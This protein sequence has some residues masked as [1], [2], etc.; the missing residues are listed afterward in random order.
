MSCH[1][2]RINKARNSH[3]VHQLLRHPITLITPEAELHPNVHEDHRG[4]HH[5]ASIPNVLRKQRIGVLPAKIPG[6]GVEVR[7]SNRT[8]WGVMQRGQRSELQGEWE[9]VMGDPIQ[10][11]TFFYSRACKGWF[12][13]TRRLPERNKNEESRD[14]PQMEGKK[15]QRGVEVI[16]RV[17]IDVFIHDHSWRGK[18]SIILYNKNYTVKHKS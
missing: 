15:D 17:T 5:D 9:G 12:I 8:F 16:L 3:G 2:I 18:L 11:W 1:V 7:C 10:T 13:M 14:R 6:G 4:D